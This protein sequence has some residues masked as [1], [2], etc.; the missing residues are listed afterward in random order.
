MSTT[1][2]RTHE[3]RRNT[4]DASVRTIHDCGKKVHKRDARALRYRT[5]YELGTVGRRWAPN[6][7]HRHRWNGQRWVGSGFD[8]RTPRH[9]VVLDQTDRPVIT[10]NIVLWFWF[11]AVIRRSLCAG[12]RC[13][14]SVVFRSKNVSTLLPHTYWTHHYLEI[15]FRH[16]YP[17]YTSFQNGF[18]WKPLF[19]KYSSGFTT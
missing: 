3:Q 5:P 17:N 7:R 14:P 15:E 16:L 10:M 6:G 9:S 19:Y 18:Y 11:T 8:A 13:N 1:H 4:H 12:G 2:A